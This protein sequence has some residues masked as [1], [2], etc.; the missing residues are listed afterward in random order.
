MAT[1]ADSQQR[2]TGP[3]SIKDPRPST[4]IPLHELIDEF[5]DVINADATQTWAEPPTHQQEEQQPVA[6]DYAMSTTSQG[7]ADGAKLNVKTTLNA[8]P[9]ANG[10][11]NSLELTP[12]V[13]A[14]TLVSIEPPTAHGLSSSLPHGQSWEH[15]VGSQKVQ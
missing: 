7:Q 14:P 4:Q 15:K 1:C 3:W 13:L 2:P 11:D 8:S 6:R 10:Y 5:N 12:T 9:T